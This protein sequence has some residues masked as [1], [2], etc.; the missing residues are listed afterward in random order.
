MLKIN[1]GDFS[2]AFQRCLYD[3]APMLFFLLFKYLD[4]VALLVLL[5]LKIVL[6]QL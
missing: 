1:T 4:H 5:I 3:L 6:L 2:L